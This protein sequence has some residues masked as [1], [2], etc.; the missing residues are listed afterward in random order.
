[1]PDRFDDHAASL[2]SPAFHGFAITPSD[3]TSLTETTRAIYV[4]SS[5]DIS[6]TLASGAAVTFASVTAG[7]I[8][9]IRASLVKSTGTTA[10]NLVGLI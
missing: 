3:V 2:E 5:G 7:T 10:T 6:V 8:L 1:M 9:P 4:G